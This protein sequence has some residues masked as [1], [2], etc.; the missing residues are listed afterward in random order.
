MMLVDRIKTEATKRGMN[1]KELATKV[2]L[3]EN[4]IYKWNK[5]S[6]NVEIL[7]RVADYLNVSTDYLLGREDYWKEYDK[8]LGEDKLDSIRNKTDEANQAMELF[9]AHIDDDLTPEEMEDVIQ[10]LEFIRS[11]HKK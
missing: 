3:S 10:Y 1:L 8:N 7:E 11:K 2:G 5:Q 9:A 6:P 4:A